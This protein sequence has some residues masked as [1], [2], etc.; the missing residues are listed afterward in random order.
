MRSEW[1][2]D[3]RGSVLMMTFG[4]MLGIVA[5]SLVLFDIYAVYMGRR[6][7]QNAADAAALGAFEGLRKSVDAAVVTEANL[8]LQSRLQ[9]ISAETSSQVSA[10]EHQRRADLTRQLEREREATCPPPSEGPPPPDAP[11]PEPCPDYSG[12]AEEVE[13]V[14]GEERPHVADQIYQSV[15]RSR[16]RHADLRSAILQG[17]T[18]EVI[19]L[20]EEFLTA[21][22]LSCVVRTAGAEHRTTWETTGGYF[23]AVNGGES[24]DFEF[25]YDGR[26]AI[27]VKVP[28]RLRLLVFD[29]LLPEHLRHVHAEA[30]VQINGVGPFPLDVRASC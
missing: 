1:L 7:A 27:G 13:R 12:I 9:L 26:T 8:R 29:R 5:L 18:P 10:W 6:V 24:P 16:I 17:R 22:D 4:I 14:I 25:P 20:V 15:V 23:A 21:Q 2:K 11:A 19:W 30:A 3:E 28:V